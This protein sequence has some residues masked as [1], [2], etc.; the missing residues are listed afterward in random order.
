MSSTSGW[1]L[2]LSSVVLINKTFGDAESLCLG[3]E[4]MEESRKET[5]LSQKRSKASP[6]KACHSWSKQDVLQ[7]HPILD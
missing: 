3:S 7:I 1:S 5:E 6:T 2:F 4:E